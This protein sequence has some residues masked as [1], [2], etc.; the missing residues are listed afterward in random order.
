[1]TDR[2]SVRKRLFGAK[3]FK[4]ESLS[5]AFG[6]G[7]PVE[8][9]VKQ[10]TVGEILDSQNTQDPKKSLVNLMIQYCYVPGSKV[11]VFEDADFNE[12]MS[13]P[14]GKWLTDFNTAVAKLTNIDIQGSEGN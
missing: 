6:E 3:K 5:L 13:W 14:V 12:I 11:R 10:P 7:D 1:M 4:T 2:D 8:I 9:E